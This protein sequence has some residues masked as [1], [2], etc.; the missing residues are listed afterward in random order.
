MHVST[1]S[2]YRGPIT[3]DASGYANLTQPA[4][5]RQIYSTA[6]SVV[7]VKV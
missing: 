3:A 1:V 7:A 5:Q 6:S 2:R 4:K